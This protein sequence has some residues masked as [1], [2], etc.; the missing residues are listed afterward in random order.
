MDD[1]GGAMIHVVE[2][3]GKA[4]WHTAHTAQASHCE[5]FGSTEH[6][7]TLTQLKLD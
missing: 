7:L 5:V 1:E 2:I 3:G 4:M 6:H